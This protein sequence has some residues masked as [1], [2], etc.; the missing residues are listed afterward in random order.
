[1]NL[2]QVTL[3]AKNVERS[4]EFYR[5]LGFAQIVSNLPHYARFECRDGGATFS[6]HQVTAPTTPE[7]IIYFECDDLDAT[8]DRLRAQ[9]FD[10]DHAPKDQP[11]LWRETHLRDPDGNVLCLYHAGTNRRFPPWRLASEAAPGFGSTV[12]PMPTEV[13]RAQLSDVAGIAALVARYWEFEEIPG[14]EPKRTERL[15]STLISLPER[16]HCW[17]AESRGAIRGYL[18][19]VYVFSLEHGGTM[20]EIDEFFV[21]PDFRSGGVGTGLLTEL[22]RE[23]R[24]SGLLRVQLQLSVTNSR[25]RSFYE[26]HGYRRRSGYELLD[27]PL[28]VG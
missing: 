11:W 26:R 14:F 24:S 20:A 15:L 12:K 6:L 27:K 16:G 28:S 2:N 4:A 22:E 13:R 10:F 1:M 23:M 7:A 17:V 3:P 21:H 5:R 9:G 18:I 19:A 25:A 8:Y